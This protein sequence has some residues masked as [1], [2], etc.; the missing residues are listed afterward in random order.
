MEKE[1]YLL[2]LGY[3]GLSFIEIERGG[4]RRCDLRVVRS[5]AAGVVV[6]WMR[7]N[8]RLPEQRRRKMHSK[9]KF[10]F[11]ERLRLKGAF[12]NLCLSHG[13]HRAGGNTNLKVC[14]RD[15]E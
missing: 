6:K 3:E 9:R 14:L 13:F 4:G 7:K 15:A 2:S 8:I 10:L 1:E 12:Q 11:Y 5:S